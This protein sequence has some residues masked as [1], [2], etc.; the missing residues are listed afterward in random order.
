[1]SYLEE[2]KRWCESPE[3]DEETRKEL[4]AIKDDEKEI[5]DR[6]YKELEFGTAG[7][8]GVMGAGTNRMNKYT[9]GKA[10]QGLANYILEKGTE[11]KGVAISYDSRNNSKKFGLQTA[12][13]LNANGIKT[14]LFENLR[15]VPELSFAVRHLGCTAGVM[16]TASHN[17]AKYNGY[18]VYWDDG[19]QIISPVDKQIIEKVRD[20]KSFSEIKTISEEDAKNKGLFN[21]I[22]K[23]MDDKYLDVLK[24]SILN[25]EIV[26][27][28]GKDLKIVYTPFHGTGN[29]VAKK[30]LNEIGFENVYV[31][32]EQAEPDGNFPTVAYPNPEDKN[33]F[34]MAL[35][36]AKEKDADLVLATDP[37]ADRL[38]IYSKDDKTGEYMEYTGNMSGLLIADY[39]ISQMKEKGILPENGMIV[40]TIVSSE[41]AKAIAKNY[42]LECIEVLTGFKYIGAVMKEAEIKK[43][44]TYL[45]GFEESYGCLIGD[46][47]RDKDGIAAVMSL[48]EA[49]SYYK[50]K[51]KTLWEAMQDIFEKYG[52]YKES[53][54]SITL[55]GAEGAKKIKEMM[56]KM[57][58]TEISKIG[59]YKVL[60]FRDIENNIKKDIQTGE[61]AETGLPKSNV[62]YY[63]LEND[64]WCCI[65]PSGTEP[66]IKVYF[67]IKGISNEDAK[68]KLENLKTAMLEIIK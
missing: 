31:V 55:E 8:R 5:E 38:G 41:L 23:E 6:F 68:V 35:D 66:K 47:A 52:Y 28:I 63:E 39:R 3:F 36:L 12:L 40:T 20:I 16:I 61:V 46:Y 51:G 64:S 29:T 17:P 56:D 27:Q 25:P 19:A 18:K 11:S 34:K 49:A 48:C 32:P 33:A 50:S 45:F 26:K 15:P 43:D 53:Q 60:S 54:V 22:G 9:V 58:N 24:K 65:R 13:I 57:R 14:Y 7:L 30:L 42:N 67:G 37:D 59:E 2:Y 4:T 62:L 1:M 44:K 21:L 10:T